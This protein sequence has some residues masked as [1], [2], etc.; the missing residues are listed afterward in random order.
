ME[1]CK[2]KDLLAEM[3]AEMTGDF[4]TLYKVFVSER[5][6]YLAWSLRHAAVPIV[7]H[8]PDGGK[9]WRTYHLADQAAR[10]CDRFVYSIHK[11]TCMTDTCF[12]KFTVRKGLWAFSCLGFSDADWLGR[13]T[14]ITWSFHLTWYNFSPMQSPKGLF[15]ASSLVLLEL[16]IPQE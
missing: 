8:N 1:R 5:D 9:A 11:I 3:L 12:E 14:L 2:Q 13:Q 16:D 15:L 6:K 4:P 7:I 10:T